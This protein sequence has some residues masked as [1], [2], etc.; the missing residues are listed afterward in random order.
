MLALDIKVKGFA[1][2]D[3]YGRKLYTKWRCFKWEVEYESMALELLIQSLTTELNLCMNQTP[4]VWFYDKRFNDNSRLVD[5]IQKVDFFE[6]YKE[7]MT[8]QLVVGVFDKVQCEEAN[9]EALEPICVIPPEP[10][11]ETPVEV[12]PEAK[13]EVEAEAA[14]I[15]DIE[16]D[17]EPDMFDNPE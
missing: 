16:P 2:K 3:S 8:C 6:M 17:R 11:N 7:E 14:A 4:T 1:S 12:E 5:E 15:F 13:V 9:F 10:A